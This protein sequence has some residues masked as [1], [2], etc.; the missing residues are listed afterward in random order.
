MLLQ[1][2]SLNKSACGSR[3]F[4]GR[5]RLIRAIFLPFLITMAFIAYSMRSASLFRNGKGLYCQC[6]RSSSETRRACWLRRRSSV[7]LFFDLLTYFLNFRSTHRRYKHVT[8]RKISSSR[9]HHIGHWRMR[10]YNLWER[11]STY[12]KSIHLQN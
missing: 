5:L 3:A 7:Y 9:Y 8:V 4:M 11:G 10:S 1:A 2:G 12:L 6:I